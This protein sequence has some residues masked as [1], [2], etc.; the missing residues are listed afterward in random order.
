LRSYLRGRHFVKRTRVVIA[1]LAVV[2]IITLAAQIEYPQP[3]TRAGEIWNPDAT[4]PNPV[5]YRPHPLTQ[6]PAHKVTP[7]DIRRFERELSN[8]GRWGADDTRAR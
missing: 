4:R 1:L 2:A 7:E 5:T 8:W 6:H 3:Q